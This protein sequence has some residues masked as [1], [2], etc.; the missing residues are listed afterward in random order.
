MAFGKQAWHEHEHEHEHGRG[1]M[2]IRLQKTIAN[3]TLM[4]NESLL[5]CKF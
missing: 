1:V 5:F 4:W 3:F 2:K